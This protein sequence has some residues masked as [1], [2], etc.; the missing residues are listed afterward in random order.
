MSQLALARRYR[1]QTFQAVVGQEACLRALKAALETQRLHH[2]YLFTG[3]RGVGKTTLARILAKCLN[4]EQG[5]SANPCE[6]CGPCQA[7]QAGSFLD[8]VEVD[9]A[10]RTKVEDT[11]ELLDNVQYLPT[12][13]RFK[14][15]LIDEVHM[16]S[17]HSFNALLKTLEEPPAHVKFLL[18]T[19]D[20]Q[21][22]PVTVLSR[23]LQFHLSRLPFA[24][25]V[26][27]LK[28][29]LT[30]ENIQ[31]EIEALEMLAYSAEGSLRDALSLLDQA[32]AY[33]YG[34][35]QTSG[36]SKQDHRPCLL[37]QEVRQLLGL[38]EKQRLIALIF[39]VAKGQAQTA[40]QEL[41][42]MADF[43]PDFSRV[44]IECL[45]LLHQIAIAQQ[46]P[47]ALEEG[48]LQREAILNFAKEISPEQVQL[49]YQIAFLGQ[50]DLPYAPTPR[51]G[52]E[53]VIL[54]MLAFQ[55]VQV[56]DPASPGSGTPLQK[57]NTI[58][59]TA[60]L[61][62][63]SL[64]I[65]PV[66]NTQPTSATTEDPLSSAKKLA[67]EP[68][69]EQASIRKSSLLQEEGLDKK[70]QA[71]QQTPS[72]LASPSSNEPVHSHSWLEILPV[73]NLGG[74]VKELAYHCS[75]VEWSDHHIHL[76]LEDARK[77]LL[78]KRN[79]DRLQEALCQH[80]N[81]AIR[82]KITIGERKHDTLAMHQ[83]KHQN[84]AQQKAEELMSTDPNVL[85]LIDQF[86]AKIE[87]ITVM[88]D[89]L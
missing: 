28:T 26:E 73:L 76:I 41:A 43:S 37:A 45:S 72:R 6:G 86:G 56:L 89:P 22:L 70:A 12:Y 60:A 82:L 54:R 58:S 84:L 21:K 27:H 4:C 46:V 88:E 48:T 19:T 57:A 80:L 32:I 34:A 7:I 29:I 39:A 3:T 85:K 66:K 9:A 78:T 30:A 38:T 52:F 47:E 23:C 49:F 64:E 25:I 65:A 11:R 74:M 42:L 69:A 14:I 33:M 61:Q 71:T 8:V 40:L 55:P 15:Y 1:P 81:K 59:Q 17:G 18:A 75:L 67:G 51:M 24:Q 44:L 53:M 35:D 62:T 10:S 13:G 87:E 16:L 63:S 68:S 5:I 83:E 77:L 20:P 50:K 79:E 31:Y 2:A 36:E